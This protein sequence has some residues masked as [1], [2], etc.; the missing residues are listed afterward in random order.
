MQ[1]FYLTLRRFMHH[2]QPRKCF[3]QCSLYKEGVVCMLHGY[4]LMEVQAAPST[5]YYW[6]A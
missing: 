5:I 2:S 4:N 3:E 6:G 1:A